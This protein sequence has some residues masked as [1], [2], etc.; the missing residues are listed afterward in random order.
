M[1]TKEELKTIIK[2]YI[3]Q[4]RQEARSEKNGAQEAQEAQEVGECE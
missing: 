2:E 3:R 1:K 4:C